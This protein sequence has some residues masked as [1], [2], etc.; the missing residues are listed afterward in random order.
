[1]L[2]CQ[3]ELR[4]FMQCLTLPPPP[5]ASKASPLQSSRPAP[6]AHLRLD[7][8]F[9]KALEELTIRLAHDNTQETATPGAKPSKPRPA[10]S[11]QN[12][13]RASPSQ[14]PAMKR[15][16]S[17]GSVGSRQ[18]SPVSPSSKRG[19]TGTGMPGRPRN[20]L[21]QWPQTPPRLASRLLSCHSGNAN[22]Q[23]SPSAAST[24]P[25]QEAWGV[26]AP[27]EMEIDS[28]Q[29]PPPD[30]DGEAGPELQLFGA[31]LRSASNRTSGSARRGRSKPKRSEMLLS[32]G[33]SRRGS[34]NSNFSEIGFERKPSK[35]TSK[36]SSMATSVSYQIQEVDEAPPRSRAKEFTEQRLAQTLQLPLE[37]VKQAAHC[38]RQHAE[39]EPPKRP[40]LW[41]LKQSDFEK[42]LCDLCSVA[43][44]KELS[45]LFVSKAFRLADMTKSGDLDLQ[46]F[47]TWYATFSFSEELLLGKSTKNVR[48]VARTLGINLLD[49]ERYK[50]VFDS[51]DKNK[52]GVI[53]MAEFR[54]MVNRL[55]KVPAGHHLPASVVKSFWN[56]ADSDGNGHIDFPE[57]CEFYLTLGLA[58]VSRQGVVSGPR[59]DLQYLRIAGDM[60]EQTQAG[61]IT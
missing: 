61:D 36:D 17:V 13:R 39:C 7:L 42:V 55:L 18:S 25:P 45:Q 11:T 5:A 56:M 34:S 10:S 51:Y 38:F 48:D 53:E 52:S 49:I 22:L 28:L 3:E 20:F 33:S 57:F 60:D 23:G 32:V 16:R 14:A 37:V 26:S 40:D 9:D 2:R 21:G 43:D 12:W 50:R 29:E 31:V 24:A 35:S 41:R 4:T 15:A 8:P 6:R 46:E 58:E 44:T 30:M 19:L 47:V 54:L 27:P 59:G 1:M